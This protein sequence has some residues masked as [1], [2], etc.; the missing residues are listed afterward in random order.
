L[1]WALAHFAR[2]PW[3]WGLAAL[4]LGLVPF[5]H[6]ASPLPSASADASPLEL[7]L[8]WAFPVAVLGWLALLHALLGIGGFLELV[9]PSAR[10]RAALAVLVAGALAAELPMAL[11]AL[12]VTRFQDGA[13]APEELASTALGGLGTLA[14]AL[15]LAALGA[16]ALVLPWGRLPRLLLAA[17]A[18]LA[19]PALAGPT[20]A[21]AFDAG[22]HVARFRAFDAAPR[23]A[24]LHLTP[25]AGLSLAGACL[26]ARL[27]GAP[28]PE[29]PR[30]TPS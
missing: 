1:R 3:A 13:A 21:A 25:I 4:L 30:P 28:G 18:A 26:A 6:A 22:G 10:W 17:A 23:A 9:P 5:T 14:L 29:A 27:R 8:A 11:G 2:Q 19:L 15:H 24:L 16:L 7:A 20:W 12:L